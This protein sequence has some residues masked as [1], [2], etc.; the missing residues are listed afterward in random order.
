[1]RRHEL[2]R[3]EQDGNVMGPGVWVADGEVGG[4]GCGSPAAPISASLAGARLLRHGRV[5]GVP[6]QRLACTLGLQWTGPQKL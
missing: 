1:M 6:R 5:A 4:L 3:V 2:R